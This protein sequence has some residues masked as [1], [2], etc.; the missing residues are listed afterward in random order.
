MVSFTHGQFYSRE[1]GSG[2]HCVDGGVGWL[3]STERGS[4]THCVVGGVSCTVGLDSL[5]LPVIES[6]FPSYPPEVDILTS[7]SK[8]SAFK[9]LPPVI[10]IAL[11]SFNLHKE[12]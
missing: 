8:L 10:L 7:S 6:G 3:Y 12:S 5:R 4:V 2:T 9:V 11:F 1:M